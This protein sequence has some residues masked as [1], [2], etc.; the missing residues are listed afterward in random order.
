MATDKKKG[1]VLVVDDTPANLSVITAMLNHAE[2]DVRPAINGEV[3]LRALANKLPDLVLLDINMPGISGYEVCRRIKADART[4]DIP[5]IF[6]SAADNLEDKMEAFRVGGVDYVTKPFQVEEVLARVNTQVTL[7]QQRQKIEALVSFKDE[8][9]RTVS[10]DLKNPLNNI[11]G[12]SDM[13]MENMRSADL[14]VDDSLVILERI[15]RSTDMMYHLV[16]TL[17]DLD[18]LEGGIRLEI[19]PTSLAQLLEDIYGQYQLAA[20]TKRINLEIRHQNETYITPVDPAR[21]AQALS[22][23]VSNAIKYTPEGGNVQVDLGRHDD[24]TVI[25]I[26]DNGYGIPADALPNLFKKFYR[27]NT[28]QHRRV[29]GTGLGLSIVKAIVD[30]HGGN[31]TVESQPGQ[32]SIFHVVL[33]V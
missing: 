12:Y 7:A 16:V 23:L 29:E 22:N 17:L 1:V 18:R 32:G 8:L 19:R 3:A 6:L 24:K 26:M 15:R 27:V 31:I 10:H 28:D 33:P 11:M 9:L 4:R 2:Y 13:L 30:L 14:D 21:F 25:R 5:V 20:E